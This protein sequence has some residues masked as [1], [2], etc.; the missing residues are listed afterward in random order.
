MNNIIYSLRFKLIVFSILIEIIMLS[1]LIFNANRLIS[2]HLTSETYKQVEIIKSNFQA[3]ILPLLIERDYA[4]LDA[5]LLEY[6]NSKNIV[7]IF[8]LNNKKILSNSNWTNEN[9][10]PIEDKNIETSKKIF[11]SQIDIKYAGQIFG[12]VY[13]GLNTEFLEKAQEELFSQSLII[14]LIEILLTIILSSGILSG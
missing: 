3:S 9:E 8:I 5:L 14:A 13:F 11:N 6:T 7:Y 12:T 10:I 4:S 2:Y 1:V